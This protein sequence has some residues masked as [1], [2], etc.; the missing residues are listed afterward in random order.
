M[1]VVLYDYHEKI[2]IHL[3]EDIMNVDMILW[4][5]KGDCKER[6]RERAHWFFSHVVFKRDVTSEIGSLWS[7]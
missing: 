7:D 5:I 1:R 2:D 4:E 3:A 6:E